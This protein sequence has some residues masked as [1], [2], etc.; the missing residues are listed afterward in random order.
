MCGCD[1]LV[2]F[3]THF[4]ISPESA[5]KAQ[6][7]DAR[8]GS[9]FPRVMA[10]A[11]HQKNSGYSKCKIEDSVCAP[12]SLSRLYSR[13]SRTPVTSNTPPHLFQ[14]LPS[15]PGAAPR[16]NTVAPG[17]HMTAATKRGK[18]RKQ[19]IHGSRTPPAQ[20]I[21]W[22]QSRQCSKP[23]ATAGRRMRA[24]RPL[25]RP[26]PPCQPRAVPC[27]RRGHAR[28]AGQEGRAPILQPR[29]HRL[30]RPIAR[31]PG[32]PLHAVHRGGSRKKR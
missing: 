20:T 8:R 28:T 22:Q 27:R 15:T 10:C 11:V 6:C 3:L 24:A 18:A 30:R 14:Q 13:L 19:P 29:G 32:L 7:A 5:A 12:L 21:I 23:H 17:A 16:G 26:Q 4:E 31:R 1:A 25:L 9:P 2:F